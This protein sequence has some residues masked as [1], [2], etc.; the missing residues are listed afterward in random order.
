M[1]PTVAALLKIISYSWKT[2]KETTWEIPRYRREGNIT[3]NGKEIR[4]DAVG[5]IHLDQW[6]NLGNSNEPLGFI[7]GGLTEQLLASQGL[8]S[9]WFITHYKRNFSHL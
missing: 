1:F 7:K 2:W 8:W 3:R 4:C 6:Q 9:I 5:W